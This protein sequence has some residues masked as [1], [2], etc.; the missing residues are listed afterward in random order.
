LTASTISRWP[1]LALTALVL[2]LA[3]AASAGAH[4]EAT[5]S[6]SDEVPNAAPPS[7]AGMAPRVGAAYHRLEPCGEI[8]NR[9]TAGFWKVEKPMPTQYDEPRAVRLGRYAYL[10]GGIADIDP[11][12]YVATSVNQFLR[13]DF[14]TKTYKQMAGMPLRLSHVGITT[15]KGNIYTAGGL[16]DDLV[17][18]GA[19]ARSFK[20]DVKRNRWSEIASLP[21]ARGAHGLVTV[22]HFMYAIGGVPQGPPGGRQQTATRLPDTSAYDFNTGKW[23]ARAPIPT[24]RDHLGVAVYKGQIYTVGGRARLDYG[25]AEFERYDPASNTWAKLPNIP[26]GS[27]GVQI[28]PVNDRLV[29]VSGGDDLTNWVDGRV[30]S[31]NP[32]LG[33]WWQL[34]GIF[35]KPV[36]G[37]AATDNSAGRIHVFG[38]S[39]CASFAPITNAESLFIG[40]SGVTISRSAVR[41]SGGR[42]RVR[43]FCG[44][45]APCAG[46]LRLYTSK[47]VKLGKRRLRMKVGS[48][49]FGI[50]G[51]KA[52]RV[53]VQLTRRGRS[54]V[55]RKGKLRLLALTQRKDASGHR[56][57]ARF[58]IKR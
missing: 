27:S 16:T 50:A 20:Y 13:Y 12:T 7:L 47:K 4:P 52:G 6:A 40:S 17:T 9:G 55:R 51:Y 29:V 39:E 45:G 26:Q 46:T 42:A 3:F 53:K 18:P 54:M 30:F 57:S 33:L 25:R 38:G 28:V 43:M 8:R 31:Y 22:G 32:A 35:P 11:K 14:K 44:S 24:P 56:A 2:G 58:L 48:G 37:Y 1:A 41:L 21:K 36:H 23:S 15:Y 5:L 19:T 49:H 34:P 10:A